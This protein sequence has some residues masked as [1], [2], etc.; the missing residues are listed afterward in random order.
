MSKSVCISVGSQVAFEYGFGTKTQLFVCNSKLSIRNNRLDVIS[1]CCLVGTAMVVDNCQ[2]DVL[3]TF[4]IVFR[5]HR[6]FISRNFFIV[7]QFPRSLNNFILRAGC[8]CKIGDE[9]KTV[10]KYVAIK[11]G[12]ASIY[13]YR[14]LHK[15]FASHDVFH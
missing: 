4:C 10:G 15:C 7:P 13:F 1:H 5:L 11:S 9:R 12:T 3:I 14:L 2:N 8:V 6:C